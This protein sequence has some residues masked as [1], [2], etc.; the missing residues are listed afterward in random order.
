[1]PLSMPLKRRAFLA[2]AILAAAPLL[3]VRPAAAAQNVAE[4]FVDENIHKGLDILKDKKLNIK[5]HHLC[6]AKAALGPAN[7]KKTEHQFWLMKAVKWGVPEYAARTMLCSNCE[8]YYDTKMIRECMK[9]YPQITP[10]EVDP[11]WVDTKDSGAYCDKYDIT[12]TASRTCD[13]WEPG[14]P[15]TDEKIAKEGEE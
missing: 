12:C 7:P 5:N 13:S 15:M 8:H 10:Q 14:G 3:M 1:M 4:A 9:K 11:S 2:F 6:I